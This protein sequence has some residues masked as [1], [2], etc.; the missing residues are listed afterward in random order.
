MRTFYAMLARLSEHALPF[1]QFALPDFFLNGRLSIVL[2]ASAAAH[3]T[4]C[5][6]VEGT[7]VDRLRWRGRFQPA[8]GCPRI[9]KDYAADSPPTGRQKR[10]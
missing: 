6:L 8:G 5:L 9:A 2:A 3:A 10:A 7:R 1:D 4:L